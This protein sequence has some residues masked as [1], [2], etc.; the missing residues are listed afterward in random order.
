MW[1]RRSLLIV[2][3]SNHCIFSSIGAICHDRQTA[4][5][6]YIYFEWTVEALIE[7]DEGL[8]TID[9]FYLLELVVEHLAQVLCITTDDLDE[10]AIVARSIVT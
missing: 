3:K 5:F 2:E 6:L 4:S 8:R 1:L 10:E 9:T 7:R